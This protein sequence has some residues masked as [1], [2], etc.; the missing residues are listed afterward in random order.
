MRL[1]RTMTVSLLLVMGSVFLSEEGVDAQG[2]PLRWERLKYPYSVKVSDEFSFYNYLFTKAIS[3]AVSDLNNHTDIVAAEGGGT[4]SSDV[5]V[6]IADYCIADISVMGFAE[7]F[8]LDE[9][10]LKSCIY[11]SSVVDCG[12]LDKVVYARIMINCAHPGF[13]RDATD[14]PI[15]RR[16]VTHELGHVASLAHPADCSPSSV[17]KWNIYCSGQREYTT[18]DISSINSIY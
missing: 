17:M 3:G 4:T 13:T 14:Y 6:E 2:T 16:V 15:R 5:V 12:G 9:G 7:Q 10:I 1:N 18:A 11:Q 8:A